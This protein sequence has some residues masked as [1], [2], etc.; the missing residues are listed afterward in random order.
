MESILDIV[1]I[2]LSI[3]LII[4]IMM[5]AKGAG[6]GNLFGGGDTPGITKTRRGLEKTLFNVTIGLSIVFFLNALL[7]V[8]L[9][10]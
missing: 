10:G 5:Q 2:L 1:Q 6:L 7:V 3:A 8:V 9:F 4:V